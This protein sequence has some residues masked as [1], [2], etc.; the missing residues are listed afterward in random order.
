VIAV[1]SDPFVQEI[2]RVGD[3]VMFSKYAGLDVQVEGRT[4]RSLEVR[5]LIAII[6]QDETEL[7]RTSSVHPPAQPSDGSP[8]LE[9][10]PR[11]SDDG[12]QA[13]PPPVQVEPQTE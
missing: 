13:D 10:V 5:E 7:N 6:R 3:L 1:G 11:S 4:Y 12:Q 2:T 9:I 8:R